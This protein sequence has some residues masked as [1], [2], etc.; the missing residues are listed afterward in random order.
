MGYKFVTGED[1]EKIFLINTLE[2]FLVIGLQMLLNFT[3]FY[4]K[5]PTFLYSSDKNLSP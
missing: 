3:K 1:N 4:I 2:R 5:G